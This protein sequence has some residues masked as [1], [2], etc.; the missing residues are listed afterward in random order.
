LKCAVMIG[1]GEAQAHL[2]RSLPSEVEWRTGL[3]GA[4]ANVAAFSPESQGWLDGL[5]AALEINRSLLADLLAEHLPA[6]R[7]LPPQAGYLAWVDVAG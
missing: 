2:L 1:G 6:A 7:Y 3:F 5:L 4:L